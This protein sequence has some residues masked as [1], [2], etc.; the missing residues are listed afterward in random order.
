MGWVYRINS[1]VASSPVGRWFQLEGS[2]HVGASI[3]LILLVRDV[4]FHDLITNL[5]LLVEK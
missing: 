1:R 5:A 3:L 4:S 2:G